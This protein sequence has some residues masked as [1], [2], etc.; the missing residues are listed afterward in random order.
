[1]VFVVA[2]H[3]VSLILEFLYKIMHMISDLLGD[4]F[5]STQ[6]GDWLHSG[7]TI[8]FMTAI[9]MAI[10]TVLERGLN[11]VLPV[12]LPAIMWGS[13]LVFLITMIIKP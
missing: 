7:F 2:Q 6:L 13:W 12:N 3:W 11:K 8:L 1:M 4:I 10:A 9:V 5:A